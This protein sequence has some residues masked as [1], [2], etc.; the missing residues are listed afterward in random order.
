M[1][2]VWNAGFYKMKLNIHHDKTLYKIIAVVMSIFLVSLFALFTAAKGLA[3]GVFAVLLVIWVLL[4][5][6]IQ[7]VLYKWLVLDV[8]GKN[9][10]AS[11]VKSASGFY[12]WILMTFIIF[13][14]TL[15]ML[16]AVQKKIEKTF[17]PA[18]KPLNSPVSI[19][20]PQ[21]L[22]PGVKN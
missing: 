20:P 11:A 19:I 15:G 21:E 10:S 8:P 9:I 17:P 14:L 16:F 13:L 12:I 1:N 18:P 4:F 6:F 3:A 2:W 7:A 22:T 5:C